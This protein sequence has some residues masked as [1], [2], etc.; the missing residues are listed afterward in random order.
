MA[1]IDERKLLGYIKQ[2]DSKLKGHTK[3]IDICCAGGTA[4][5]LLGTKYLSHD[6]DLIVSHEDSVPLSSI[7]AEI[8]FKAKVTIDLIVE[9]D[10]TYPLPSDYKRYARKIGSFENLD[11]YILN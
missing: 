1:K 2:I 7:T 9:G 3:R 6:I 8:E 11:L 4:L 5:T 10:L